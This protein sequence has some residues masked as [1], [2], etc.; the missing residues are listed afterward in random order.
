MAAMAVA[1]DLALVGVVDVVVV[2][3]QERVFLVLDDRDRNVPHQGVEVLGPLHQ[4]DRED[5]LRVLLVAGLDGDFL[6]ERTCPSG[7]KPELQGVAQVDGD[8]Q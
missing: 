2:Q 4:A 5:Q 7:A 1:D 3:G 6:L 8:G